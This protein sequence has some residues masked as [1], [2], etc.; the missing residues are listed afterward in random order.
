MGVK[1]VNKPHQPGLLPT[2]IHYR[3]NT[4]QKQTTPNTFKRPFEPTSSKTSKIPGRRLTSAEMDKKRAKGLYFFCDEKYVPGHKCN[5]NKQ[6]FLVDMVEEEQVKKDMIDKSLTEYIEEGDEFMTISLQA[7][8]G[9]SGYQTIRVTGYHEKKPLQVLIDTGSTHNFID[10]EVAKKLGYKASSIMEQLVSVADG[11]RVQT[12]SWLNTLGRVIFDFRNRTIYFMY[13][14]EKLQ[15]HHIQATPGEFLTPVISYLIKQYAS[16]FEPPTTLPPHRRAFDHR[17]PLIESANPVSKRPYRY[18]GIKKDIIEKLVQEMLDQSIIQHSTSPYA[19]P[20]VLV[21]KK[22]GCWRLCVDY[23]EL[24]QL[25]IKNKFPIPIIEDLLDELCGAVVFSN[26]DLRDGYHQLRMH[27]GDTQKTAFKTHEGHYEFLVMPFRLNNAPSSFQMPK[28]EY[29]GLFISEEGDSTNPKKIAAVANWPMPSNIKQL[30]GFLGLVGYYR[31][32]IQGYGSICRPLHDLLKKE[33]FKWCEEATAA[34]E[35]LKLALI[36]APVLAIPDYS[37]P[38]IV[39]TDASGKGR[40]FVVKTYQKALKHL[41]E[42]HIHTDFPIPGISMLM[43]FDFSIEYKK[44]VENK[45]ADALSRK[46]DFELLAI[47]LLAPHDSLFEQIKA[48]W[49]TD[50][51]LKDIILKLHTQPFKSFT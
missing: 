34:F 23:R 21:G 3:S 14:D 46:P 5:N 43:A 39:E 22:D 12:A 37:K 15:S 19:S 4:F 20:V 9:V 31:R 51:V 8:T 44:G 47:S 10:Q 41:L 2:P 32:F 36:Y 50:I 48:T 33:G 45:A 30:R 7:F 26:I 18:P 16:I 6:I 24:N 13:Q 35:K 29:L 42:Q 28:V 1:P 40:P 49:T 27:E 11:R 38:F 25:T 17:I